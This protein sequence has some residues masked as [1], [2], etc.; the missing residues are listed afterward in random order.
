MKGRVIAGKVVIELLEGAKKTDGGIYIPDN[1][2]KKE[3][4][5]KVIAVGK[6]TN[7]EEVEVSPGEE[8]LTSIH[9]GVKFDYEDNHYKLINHKDI[10]FIF[11]T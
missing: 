6:S 2:R 10:L 1:A 4:R 9:A 8:I 11:E 5:G 7:E 3:V